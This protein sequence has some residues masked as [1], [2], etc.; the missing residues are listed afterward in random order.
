MNSSTEPRHRPKHIQPVPE[1]DQDAE[2]VTEVIVDITD[3]IVK[4]ILKNNR[5]HT[6]SPLSPL[7]NPTVNPIRAGP[8]RTPSMD[9]APDF[10]LTENSTDRPTTVAVDPPTT[11]MN[12][13]TII[14]KP[15]T[16]R[17]KRSL[18]LEPLSYNETSFSPPFLNSQ[19]EDEV[20]DTRL[21]TTDKT[22]MQP[23]SQPRVAN[24]TPQQDEP[25]SYPTE[26]AAEYPRQNHTVRGTPAP[27]S[28]VDRQSRNEV[29]DPRPTETAT[30]NMRAESPS[31][32]V[33][34]NTGRAPV[35]PNAS[36]RR[37]P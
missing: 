23:E 18:L 5:P 14:S 33:T 30:T 36:D 3:N 4:P 13:E 21:I 28:A 6:S 22:N 16:R 24:G 37:I 32:D 9:I 12:T 31:S 2:R 26:Q 27:L 11:T 25:R 7:R 19:S 20:E 1:F 35:L 10:H 34:P 8:L 29:E 17:I 15:Q